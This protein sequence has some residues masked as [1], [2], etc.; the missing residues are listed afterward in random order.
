MVRKHWTFLIFALGIG[1]LSKNMNGV[2]LAIAFLLVVVFLILA[3]VSFKRPIN[4]K[5]D[6]SDETIRRIFS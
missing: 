1:I 6:V 3:M 4:G 2:P 5:G